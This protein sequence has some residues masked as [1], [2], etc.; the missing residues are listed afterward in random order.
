MSLPTIIDTVTAS[1][2]LAQEAMTCDVAQSLVDQCD[3]LD[4]DFVESL[5]D[6]LGAIALANELAYAHESE[7]PSDAPLYHAAMQLKCWHIYKLGMLI[8]IQ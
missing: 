4:E 3:G 7:S 6:N 5:R 2:M 8:A 1:A